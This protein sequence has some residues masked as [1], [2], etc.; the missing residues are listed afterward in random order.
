M[1]TPDN[2]Q[3]VQITLPVRIQDAL[4]E[5]DQQ[6]VRMSAQGMKP[7]HIVAQMAPNHPDATNDIVRNVRSRHR[8]V[9]TRLTL[10]YVGK[11]ALSDAC[12]A[13]AACLER[14]S[15]LIAAGEGGLSGASTALAI[16]HN[17]CQDLQAR[18]DAGRGTDNDRRCV[19]DI[20]GDIA[21]VVPAQDSKSC[22]R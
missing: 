13:R 18:I 1:K 8:D 20:T 17:V 9:I 11:L 6:I 7:R 2:P 10:D 14:I 15:T 5:R 16:V 22:A 4:S 19:R 12:G 21:A 3:N